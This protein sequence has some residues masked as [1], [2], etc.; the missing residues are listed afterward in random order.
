MLFL[1]TAEIKIRTKIFQ[2][3]ESGR[4]P[5]AKAADLLLSQDPCDFVGLL[6]AA[7][8]QPHR[9]EGLYWTL[10][11]AY[12]GHH[13]GYMGLTK[14]YA[15]NEFLSA[16]IMAVAFGKMLV[17]DTVDGEAADNLEELLE[18]LELQRELEPAEVT[19]RLRLHRLIHRFQLDGDLDRA[20]V[21]EILAEGSAIAPLLIGLLRSWAWEKVPADE[22]ILVENA[23]ALL[24]E[25][26]DATVVS[27]V[28]EFLGM[29]DADV[30]GPS[31]W[32]LER[33]FARLPAETVEAVAQ[34]VPTLGVGSRIG[35]G[36]FLVAH[37]GFD[38]STAILRS[39]GDN[40]GRFSKK[41]CCD[42]VPALM[43]S[44]GVGL[45]TDPVLAARSLMRA[46]AQYLSKNML[47]ECEAI[48]GEIQRTTGKR[49][50]PASPKS[51]L[52]VYDICGGDAVWEDEETAEEDDIELYVPAPVTKPITMERNDIC[53]CGSGK[54]YKKCHMDSDRNPEPAV[55][56]G[57]FN[58]LRRE[59]AEFITKAAPKQEVVAA[60]DE[61][62][63]DIPDSKDR[64]GVDNATNWLVHDWV[65][66]SVGTTVIELFL[67]RHGNRLAVRERD[68]VGAW[69]RS[70][71][72]LFEVQSTKPGVG[73]ELKSLTSGD[74]VFVHDIGCSTALTMWDGIL[75][76]VVP[77]ERGMEFGGHGVA[78]ARHNLQAQLE[79]MT[80]RKTEQAVDWPTY[81]KSSWP[82]VRRSA[83]R[84]AEASFN[85]LKLN[86]SDGEEISM[87]KAVFQ[88]LDESAVGTGLR[89]STE[90]DPRED[91]IG[92]VWLRGD[93]GDEQRTLL[94]HL[95]LRDGSTGRELDL[96]TNSKERNAR[97]TALLTQ[98][99][100]PAIRHLRDE[101]TTQTEMKRSASKAQ[102]TKFL[103]SIPPEVKNK[104]IGE[105]L[106]RHYATWADVPLPA[107][108]GKTPREAVATKQGRE[109]VIDLFKDMENAQLRAAE[110]GE[111][112][113]DFSR[114]RKELGVET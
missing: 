40:L 94:G 109:A 41:E 66:H 78:V 14:V 95:E 61:F 57:E 102:P 47:R 87:T 46:N 23:L 26:G 113:Y 51:L 13:A 105:I 42:L 34:A 19:E 60:F 1:S 79:W 62:R 98:L 36:L 70:Y 73:V 112:T 55:N 86:N 72:D 76:R 56:S 39:L 43:V 48:L 75:S 37:P 110:I 74:V 50:D 17:N 3:H 6:L 49:E 54:K 15:E 103:D 33:L 18:E 64:D 25:I 71:T 45:T 69:A 35:L 92:Y 27:P 83:Y 5:E 82:D 11:T 63:K 111:P 21:D 2:D 53:W 4:I 99:L 107:L 16:G 91:G 67:K 38:P 89:G 31:D 80:A 96:V 7:E 84:F 88:V 101:I 104:V 12:S 22:V 8:A 28:L 93:T 30:N 85:N 106:E 32:A 9:A 58:F 100:G 114:L 81:L 29:E 59:L 97:G 10:A 44:F 90:F 108:K 20:R 65:P 24:G 68:I 77:A 52:T